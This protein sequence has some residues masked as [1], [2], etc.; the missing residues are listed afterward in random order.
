MKTMKTLLLLCGCLLGG[1][2]FSQDCKL[3]K[4]TDEFSGQ[5]KIS[6]GFMPLQS[7]DLSID[8]TG[9]E[10]DYFFVIHNPVANCIGEESEAV[11]L[12]EGGK[13]KFQLRNSGGDNCNGYF[14]IIMKGGAYTPS[15]M[16]KLATKRIVSI[17]FTDRNEKKTIVTLSEQEQEMLMKAS[18]C[19]AK[20]AKNLPR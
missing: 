15:A 11:F 19:V 8:A 3:Q 20:E 14:H 18:D 9:R 5:P 16:Q 13:T 1:Q 17:T 12:L 7:V 10:I 4:S 6:T 2:V